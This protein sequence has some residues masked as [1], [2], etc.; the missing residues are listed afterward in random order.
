MRLQPYTTPTLPTHSPT[1]CPAQPP[2][3]G[4]HRDCG[5]RGVAHHGQPVDGDLQGGGGGRSA[6]YGHTPRSASATARTAPGRTLARPQ[7]APAYEHCDNNPHP[8]THAP[9]VSEPPPAPALCPPASARLRPPP[10]APAP[11]LLLPSCRRPPPAAP[12]PHTH[13]VH[14]GRVELHREPLPRHLQQH[15]PP[16]RLA[17]GQGQRQRPEVQWQQQ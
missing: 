10:P 17:V 9:A 14:G 8:R 6:E 1:P 4:P 13:L 12:L 16:P 7:H 2:P 3:P 15:S 5:G 11:R